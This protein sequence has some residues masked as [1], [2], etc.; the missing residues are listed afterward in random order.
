MVSTAHPRTSNSAGLLHGLDALELALKAVEPPVIVG[1]QVPADRALY[2]ESQSRG[3]QHR[4]TIS[5][6]QHHVFRHVHIKPRVQQSSNYC[7]PFRHEDNCVNGDSFRRHTAEHPGLPPLII[8]GL[9]TRSCIKQRLD[10]RREVGAP[11]A[12]RMLRLLSIS[13]QRQFGHFRLF[14]KHPRASTATQPA[15]EP[16]FVPHKR[17][18]WFYITSAEVCVHPSIHTEP[19]KNSKPPTGLTYLL[20]RPH[21]R[22][23]LPFLTADII[24]VNSS[25]S[26][27]SLPSRSTF[28]GIWLDSNTETDT[29]RGNFSEAQEK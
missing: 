6:H 7:T 12:F 22:L 1:L 14:E 2:A 23:A 3:Q 21:P 11:V 24:T 26:T 8:I 5:I 28:A 15:I 4:S 29:F 18:S 13:R 20:I 16:T 25:K 9:H 17:S 27:Q 19:H 10:P